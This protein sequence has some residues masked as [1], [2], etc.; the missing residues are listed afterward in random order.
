MINYNLSFFKLRSVLK[1]PVV[2]PAAVGLLL[3]AFP[4]SVS[5]TVQWLYGWPNKLGYKKYI[6][7]LK[8]R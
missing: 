8:P 3:V 4:Y 6:E 5:L 2:L 1:N 7:A